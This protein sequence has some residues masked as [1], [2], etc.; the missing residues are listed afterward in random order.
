MPIKFDTT[1]NSLPVSLIE[2]DDYLIINGFVY[3]KRS[4]SLI[5]NKKVIV[6]WSNI[7][8]ASTVIY[9]N[10]I[11]SQYTMAYA[12]K[13]LSNTSIMANLNL[14]TRD[15]FVVG[16]NIQG[17][18]GYGSI[19]IDNF[20]NAFIIR[21]NFVDP[22]C[23]QV[24]HYE[25][26]NYSIGFSSRGTNCGL[27][28]YFPGGY[29][30][31]GTSNQYLGFSKDGRR[32][33]F[34]TQYFPG[35]FRVSYYDVIS[36]SLTHLSVSNQPYN[37]NNYNIVASSLIPGTENQDVRSFYFARPASS[38]SY[39]V[40]KV[41][42]DTARNSVSYDQCV[43]GTG[44][45]VSI[46][47]TDCASC[48]YT[49]ILSSYNGNL[50]L[51]V[52]RANYPGHGSVQ[53]V[54][55]SI[56]SSNMTTLTYLSSLNFGDDLVD[57]ISLDYP[58]NTDLIFATHNKG[59]YRA[60]FNGISWNVEKLI[61]T[62]INSGGLLLDEYRRLW[63]VDNNKTIY[64]YYPDNNQRIIDLKTLSKSYTYSG[65]DINDN[66]LL[67][68]YENNSRISVTGILTILSDNAIF[69]SNNSNQITVTTDINN[70]V[71]IPIKI[72][73]PG[74]L[75]ITFKIT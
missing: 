68:V 18:N 48:H 26:K 16:N 5:T 22:Y 69:T 51:T 60:K 43:V 57:Y 14:L 71:S 32:V 61:N 37:T 17:T 23:F 45:T 63:I 35:A 65:S 12:S 38:N 36:N 31:H 24:F 4:L 29:V 70:D 6:D 28:S 44:Y 58:N 74:K 59:V 40:M 10:K 3:D 39:Q 64:L 55:W 8:R 62:G 53:P 19:K 72:I 25:N 75:K 54:T 67:S 20:L 33:F 15:G 34:T 66:V 56:D 21:S 13:C 11:L 1:F 73:K 52:Y 50:Y 42:V 47:G 9:S 27:E 30:N 49:S 41:N 46:P 2:Y 7:V